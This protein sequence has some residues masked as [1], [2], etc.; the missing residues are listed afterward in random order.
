MRLYVVDERGRSGVVRNN[1]SVEAASISEEV[2]TFVE[3][4]RRNHNG[5]TVDE[6]SPWL[7]VALYANT[8]VKQVEP[9]PNDDGLTIE[10][11]GE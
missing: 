2:H 7:P 4:V 6:L 11:R 8:S 5:V 1:L 10:Y 3:E 9:R